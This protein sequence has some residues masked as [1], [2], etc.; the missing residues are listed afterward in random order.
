MKRIPQK[1]NISIKIN[2]FQDYYTINFF[3][4]KSTSC[5]FNWSHYTPMFY[6]LYYICN[7]HYCMIKYSKP[8]PIELFLVV[9]LLGN[10]ILAK[11]SCYIAAFFFFSEP[12]GKAREY[13]YHQFITIFIH[14]TKILF[15]I[16][17]Y[18]Y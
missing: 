6:K 18:K 3:P 14:K 9:A 12:C 17:N 11:I 1:E 16:Q 7:C 2:C 5:N 8:W 13:I 4:L 10:P 15:Y